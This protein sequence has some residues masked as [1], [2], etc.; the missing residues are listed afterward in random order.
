MSFSGLCYITCC[1]C[2]LKV[3]ICCV[4]RVVRGYRT[5]HGVALSV[6]T[7]L[8]PLA[9]AVRGWV[10]NRKTPQDAWKCVLRQN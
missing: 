1:K 8:E 2:T 10:E 5:S 9:A 7:E 3:R 4:S 6:L